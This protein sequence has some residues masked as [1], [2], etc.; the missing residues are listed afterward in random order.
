MVRGRPQNRKRNAHGRPANK[1]HRVSRVNGNQ[2]TTRKFRGVSQL[3][4]QI[5]SSSGSGNGTESGFAITN[6]LSSYTGTDFVSDNYEQYKVTNVEI[7]MKPSA[8][9]LNNGE[10]PSSTLESILYQNSVYSGMNQTYVQSF[11][12]YDTATNATFS[13]CLLRPSVKTR[14]LAPN[15]WTKI[16]SFTPRTLANPTGGAAPSNNFANYWMSTDNLSAPLYGLR[17]VASN[18][19]PCFDTQD[20]VMCV[21]VRVTL[22]VSMRGQK[23]PSSTTSLPLQINHP[24]EGDSEV[25]PER[26]DNPLDSLEPPRNIHDASYYISDDGPI[27]KVRKGS[28]A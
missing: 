3:F 17:G 24:T 2:T 20:N 21:D 14:A 11:V 18:P 25:S 7:L 16:A 10:Q 5:P 28:V 22:T 9:T 27:P 6:A 4:F 13:E 8:A 15:N 23:T 19:S 1:P 12:D 26:L